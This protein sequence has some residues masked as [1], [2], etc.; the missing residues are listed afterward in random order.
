MRTK[1]GWYPLE[2]IMVW[3][4]NDLHSRG[5][6]ILKV[7]G[8]AHQRKSQ[9]DIILTITKKSRSK[10]SNITAQTRVKKEETAER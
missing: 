7:Y 10:P 9:L 5:T 3:E 8:Q 1:P 2:V 6:R 4:R